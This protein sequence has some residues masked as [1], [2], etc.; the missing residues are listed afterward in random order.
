MSYFNI[1][2]EVEVGETVYCRLDKK[3]FP[4]YE[5]DDKFVVLSINWWSF[6]VGYHSVKV[7]SLENETILTVNKEDVYKKKNDFLKKEI[8]EYKKYRE[9][10]IAKLDKHLKELE[11]KLEEAKE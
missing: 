5:Y 3:R 6:L 11:D 9:N 4:W 7:V 8:E 2:K 10:E 1:D